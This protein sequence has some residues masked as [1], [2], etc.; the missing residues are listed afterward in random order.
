MPWTQFWKLYLGFILVVAAAATTALAWAADADANQRQAATFAQLERQAAV[1]AELSA[2]WLA[3]EASIADSPRAWSEFADARVTLILAN[4]RVLFDSHRDARTM[5]NHA[6][7]PEVAAALANGRG[8]AL[9]PTA[10]TDHDSYYVAQ[11]VGPDTAPLGV[12]RLAAPAEAGSAHTNS[13]SVGVIAAS[14]V[15]ALA[16]LLFGWT[17][18]R[19]FRAPLAATTDLAEAIARGDYRRSS[20]SYESAEM[21]RLSE[22]IATM[23]AQLEHRLEMMTVDRNKVLAILS[24]MVEGVVAV[25]QNERVVHINTVASKLLDADPASAVGRRI[26]EVTRI[27]AIQELL[28]R[29]RERGEPCSAECTLAAEPSN[30]G[31]AV[32]ELR[33]APLRDGSGAV[34]VLNDVTAFRKLESIRR[35][36][37]A[38][39]SHELKTPLTAIRAL[40]ETMIDDREMPE[41]TVR[42]FL[43]KI[44][45][46]SLRL[47]TLVSDLLTLARIESNV[48]TPERRT[49]DARAIV[50]E[51]ATRVG[52]VC[53]KKQITLSVEIPAE[54]VLANADEE[55]LRQIV[56]NL[57]DNACKYTSSGGAVWVRL[58]RQAQALELT[59]RDTG[60]GID[61][62]DCE[63]VFERF[64]RVDKA[65]SRELGGT[66]LGLSIVKHLVQALGG[67]VG[68]QS[69]L[70]RGSTFHVR[71]P[72]AGLD[73]PSAAA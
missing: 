25:D 26:W 61:P 31:G 68:L 12:V 20:T 64:Y 27:P 1:L 7:R 48:V 29:T 15:A 22:A 58:E 73:S 49:L 32:I 41:A 10:L 56:D 34:L 72:L 16:T 54:P 59:V 9:R 4:G 11:R 37:V 35:D 6:S 33:A 5:E 39:V 70:G 40:V 36:F 8:R 45:D 43:D 42:R 63:R 62:R 67:Q 51:C 57:L 46:Q 52:A 24:S 17:L 30:P 66:G 18:A 2:G 38:N 47:T 53:E 71:L 55:S 3:D 44:R 23:T 19:R 28:D 69:E 65:R 60:I 21:R 13:L 14:A 50:R